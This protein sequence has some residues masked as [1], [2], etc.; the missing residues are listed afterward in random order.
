MAEKD[1]PKVKS[2]STK[3]SIY[4]GE[5]DDRKK[6]GETAEVA[7]PTPEW[8]VKYDA[9]VKHFKADPQVKEKADAYFSRGL[10][11][12][13][14]THL[15]N[16]VPAD[17]WNA[18]MLATAVASFKP[19]LGKERVDQTE[20]TRRELEK[21]LGGSVTREMVLEIQAKYAKK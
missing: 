14:Q 9:F 11:V 21:Q 6:V 20:K 3:C 12:P 17:K 5:G 4:E 8:A 16:T 7:V 15:R 1:A 18:S 13:M 2:F 19:S 10:V